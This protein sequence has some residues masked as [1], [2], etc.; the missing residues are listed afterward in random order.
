MKPQPLQIDE[1]VMIGISLC[2]NKP[3]ITISASMDDPPITICTTCNT[4][5]DRVWKPK[6]EKIAKGHYRPIK[7]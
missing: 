6:Y 3:T 1:T 7:Y 4:V 2:C 5:A